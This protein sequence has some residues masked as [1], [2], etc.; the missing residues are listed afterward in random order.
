MVQP[1]ATLLTTGI[2][3][4]GLGFLAIAIPVL[5][6][7]AI[8]IGIIVLVSIRK[9]SGALRGTGFSIAAI[10][11]NVVEPVLIARALLLGILLTAVLPH[12]L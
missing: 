10:S 7:C 9:S 1:Q 4:L 8:V 11:V 3:T 12:S 5:S 6:P 2:L